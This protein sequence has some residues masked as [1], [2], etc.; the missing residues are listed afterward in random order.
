MVP[1][2]PQSD[3]SHPITPRASVTRLPTTAPF[4]ARI[5]AGSLEKL[6]VRLSDDSAI[7]GSETALNPLIRTIRLDRPDGPFVLVL[8]T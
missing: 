6:A 5:A 3:C 4:D 2:I 1:V 8:R 7:A